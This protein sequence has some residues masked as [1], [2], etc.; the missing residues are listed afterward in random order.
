MIRQL[1]V[2]GAGGDLT[3]RYLL[4]AL[5]RLKA[6][7]ALP[8]PFTVIG[9]GREESDDE[10]F[11]RHAAA[12]LQTHAADVPADARHTLCRAL[13]YQQGDASDSRSLAPV[14][15]RLTGPAVIYLALPNAVFADALRALADAGML[16]ASRIVIEKPFGN[17]GADARALNELIARVLA[18]DAVFPIDHFLA[19]E[20]VLNVLGLRF[21]NRIFEPVWNNTHVE[22]VDIVWDETL[23]VEGRAGYYDRAGALR[24][25]VQNHLLQLMTLIAMEPPIDLSE[26]ALRDRKVDLLRAVRTPSVQDVIDGSRRGRYVAGRIGTREL[27]DYADE[28]GVDPVRRTETDAEI[29]L[30]VDNWRWS[31]VPFRLRTGKALQANRREMVLRFRPVPHLPFAASAEPDVLR[32]TMDPD[33]ITLAINLNGAGDPFDLEREELL[34][35]LPRRDLPAYSLLLLQ[36]LSGDT[37]LSVRPDE[38]EESWRIVEP[39]LAAWQADTVPLEHYPAGSPPPGRGT[40]NVR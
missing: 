36:I 6:A 24:D 23:G 28:P 30:F 17:D 12:C 13:G 5:A 2:L 8:D 10:A 35:D 25:M 18:E 33:A 31:G 32:L 16:P 14:F 34:V 11:R 7:G 26:R 38:A 29:T 19:E 20:T 15:E 39:V 27:P 22:R 21:A 4:P 40:G 9:V 1:V 37:A 3:G